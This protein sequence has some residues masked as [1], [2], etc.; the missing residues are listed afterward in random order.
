MD[1]FKSKIRALKN[2]KIKA[3]LGNIRPIEYLL[4]CIP[5]VLT[6]F[7]NKMVIAGSPAAFIF[8]N[9]VFFLCLGILFLVGIRH[10]IIYFTVL[11]FYIISLLLIIGRPWEYMPSAD[12]DS[13]IKVGIEAIINGQNPFKAVTDLGHYPTSLPFTYFFYMPVYFLSNGY[14]TYMSIIIFIIFSL[15]ILYKFLD[16]PQNYL[17]LPMISFILF[18][19]WFFLETYYNMDVVNTGFLLCIILLILPDKIPKQKTFIKIL[20]IIPEKPVKIDKQ[21]LLFSI[22]FGCLLA[23]RIY[24]W[25]IGLIVILYILKNYGFKN[26]AL[27]SLLTI[28]V[29]LCWMLP[30]VLQDV[31]FFIFVNPIAHNANKFSSWRSYDTIHSKAHFILDILNEILIYNKFNGIIISIF[32]VCI[33][34]ILGIINCRNKF[35]LLLIIAFCDFIFLFFYY[36]GPFYGITRDYMSIAAIPFIFSFFYTSFDEENEEKSVLIENSDLNEKFH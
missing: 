6:M 22:L 26:T 12:R 21:A 14:V 13:A 15:T 4:I 19:D 28:S 23:M 11:L 8:I 9:L 17:I 3:L 29:F 35:H 1:L 18:A 32:I 30:F 7:T 10:R 5:I 34:I 24:F 16:T 33:S 31:D 20:K 25:I 27:L 36:F 2:E